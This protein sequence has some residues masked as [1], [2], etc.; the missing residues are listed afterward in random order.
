MMRVSALT[1]MLRARGAHAERDDRSE[2]GRRAHAERFE[3]VAR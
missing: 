1:R 2:I 3:G